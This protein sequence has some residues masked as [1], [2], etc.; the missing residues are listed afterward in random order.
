MSRGVEEVAFQE[1]RKEMTRKK[2]PRKEREGVRKLMVFRVLGSEEGGSPVLTPSEPRTSETSWSLEY[3]DRSQGGTWTDT[4]QTSP[5]IAPSWNMGQWGGHWPGDKTTAGARDPLPQMSPAQRIIW[6]LPGTLSQAVGSSP[7]IS[8]FTRLHVPKT[9]AGGA[10]LAFGTGRSRAPV[11]KWGP[12]ASVRKAVLS[13]APSVHACLP[14]RPLPKSTIKC[15][16]LCVCFIK[17]TF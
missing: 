1:S 16:L 4:V 5:E 9:A 15:F 13:G 3:G 7:D 6:T 14:A 2:D 12:Q 17:C 10:V 8:L 11:Q